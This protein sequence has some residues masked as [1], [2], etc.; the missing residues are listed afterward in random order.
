MSKPC[1]WPITVSLS[2][3]P[4]LRLPIIAVLAL[5]AFDEVPDIWILPGGAMIIGAAI[6]VALRERKLARE[7]TV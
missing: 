3:F 6:Y 4:N 1:N 2:D 7:K 5:I